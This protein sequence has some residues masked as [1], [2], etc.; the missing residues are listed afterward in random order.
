M[1]QENL[2]EPRVYELGYLLAPEIAEEHLDEKI[3]E[4]RK[5]I[6]DNQGL[7]ISEGRAELIELAYPMSKVIENKKQVYNKGYFGW[8]KFDATPE[9]VALLKKEI[10]K[11]QFVFR[12]LVITTVR[13]NTLVGSKVFATNKDGKE[14]RE[15]RES[16]KEAKPEAEEKAEP[17]NEEELDKKIDELASDE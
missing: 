10:E 14:V 5:A 15:P 3:D 8:I 17:V 11:M 12:Y 4:V 1:A 13:E 16:R 6:T 7:P 2:K 9:K